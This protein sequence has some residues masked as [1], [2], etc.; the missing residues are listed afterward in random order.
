MVVAKG[1]AP[2]N[3][4]ETYRL[5]KKIR[6]IFEEVL[7]DRCPGGVFEQQAFTFHDKKRFYEWTSSRSLSEAVFSV[8]FPRVAA[9][10]ELDH[11]TTFSA[12]KA[13]VQSSALYLFP[14]KKRLH[15]G[16]YSTFVVDHKLS[17]YEA[18]QESGRP[19]YEELVE[20]LFYASFVEVTH[21]LAERMWEDFGDRG[22]G[23]RIRLRVTPHCADL[24]K[25]AYQGDDATTLKKIADKL[26]SQ[27]ELV[28]TPWTISRICAFYLTFGFQHE[29]EVRL[30]AK[31]HVG[32]ADRTILFNQFRVWPIPI[33]SSMSGAS[34]PVCS[35]EMI[36]ITPGGRARPESVRDILE[37]S[38]F[39]SIPMIL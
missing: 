27:L 18:V 36:G 39:H 38:P 31:R 17:G 22:K 19:L 7:G 21:P 9:P 4:L 2:V 16:E 1:F 15:E 8:D 29:N 12:F 5:I 20:D 30:L 10:V 32:S 26:W 25:V 6:P 24:R 37:G 33:A 35:I 23:V 14:L 11:Y 13:I 28:Y 34:D 3:D